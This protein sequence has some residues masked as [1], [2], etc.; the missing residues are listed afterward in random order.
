MLS[1]IYKHIKTRSQLEAKWQELRPSVLA[2]LTGKGKP[3]YIEYADEQIEQEAKVLDGNC[4]CCGR[5]DE[6][7]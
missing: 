5:P 7:Q 6:H 1:S 4:P 2:V 3:E